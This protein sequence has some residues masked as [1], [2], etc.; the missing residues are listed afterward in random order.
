[1]NKDEMLQK[2]RTACIKANPNITNRTPI[3]TR[4][5]PFAGTSKYKAPEPIRLADVL[6]AMWMKNTSN[7]TRITLECAG[8]FFT[9]SPETGKHSG[10]EWDLTADNIMHQSIQVIQFIAMQL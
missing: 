6:W 7:R 9:W 2:I 5:A 3:E 10:P 4:W 8:Q 1:M